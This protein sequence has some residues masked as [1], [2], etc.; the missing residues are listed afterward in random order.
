MVK[1]VGIIAGVL[2]A[3]GIAGGPPP[4]AADDDEAQCEVG[5]VET[6]AKGSS[7][8]AT[9]CQE[10]E[11]ARACRRAGKNHRESC[12]RF[13]RRFR[14]REGPHAKQCDGNSSPVVKEMF[15]ADQHCEAWRAITRVSC[16]VRASCVCEGVYW[17]SD[18]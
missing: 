7:I 6:Y 18:S 5:G 8:E 15:N 12:E 3:L 10:Y 4:L 14:T 2:L 9:A 16:E 11:Y 13:C 1:K 17:S